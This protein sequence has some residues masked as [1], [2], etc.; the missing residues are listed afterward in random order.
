M[1]NGRSRTKP[2][3]GG[4]QVNM[5]KDGTQPGGAMHRGGGVDCSGQ[6]RDKKF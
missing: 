3:V 2:E 6:L 5:Y 4:Q 1:E